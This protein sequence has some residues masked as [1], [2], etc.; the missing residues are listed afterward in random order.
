MTDEAGQ[1]ELPELP[2]DIRTPD[3]T[4][5]RSPRLSKPINITR[6]DKMKEP[7]NQRRGSQLKGWVKECLLTPGPILIL[8]SVSETI[9]V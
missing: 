6:P 8:K 1:L 3:L 7:R 4:L 9:W 2:E 5:G